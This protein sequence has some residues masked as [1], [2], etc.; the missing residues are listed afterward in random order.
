MA[1]T[2]KAIR[3]VIHG[4]NLTHCITYEF[5]QFESALAGETTGL[6]VAV[7]SGVADCAGEVPA[8]GSTLAGDALTSGKGEDVAVGWLLAGEVATEGTELPLTPGEL[9]LLRAR[10]LP[11]APPARLSFLIT[12]LRSLT[13]GELGGRGP[14]ASRD[15]VED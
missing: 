8:Q 2:M 11:A 1:S 4:F 13:E 6:G 7:G 15:P 3:A 14:A 12:A 9:E 10:S 5:L